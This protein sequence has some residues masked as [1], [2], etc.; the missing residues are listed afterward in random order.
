MF[1]STIIV[2]WPVKMMLKNMAILKTWSPKS[3]QK[4]CLDII[5]I[6]IRENFLHLA[7]AVFKSRPYSISI[8]HVIGVSVRNGS[9]CMKDSGPSTFKGGVQT[10]PVHRYGPYRKCVIADWIYTMYIMYIWHM[11]R[12]HQNAAWKWLSTFSQYVN[13]LVIILFFLV[14]G[15]LGQINLVIWPCWGGDSHFS[16]RGKLV[17]WFIL[18]ETRNN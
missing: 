13:M 5:R 3:S 16:V 11:K 14:I 15:D 6:R 8:T 9:S 2:N 1:M 17:R 12:S 7:E 10:F 4:F 18:V